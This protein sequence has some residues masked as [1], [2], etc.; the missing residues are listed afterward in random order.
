MIKFNKTVGKSILNLIQL[1]VY[2]FFFKHLYRGQVIN[3]D[4]I[5]MRFDNNDSLLLALRGPYE[6]LLTKKFKNAVKKGDTVVDIGANIGYYTLIASKLVGKTGK[7]FAFEP[8]PKNFKI[9]SE[10]VK[11]NGRNNVVLENKA[12]SNATGKNILYLYSSIGNSFYQLND[13]S[14]AKKIEVDTIK[15]DNYFSNYHRKINVVKID[16]E[17]AEFKVFR[18]MRS[19]IRK[20]PNLII[21]TEISQKI[22]KVSGENLEDYFDL[23]VKYGF[24]IYDIDD[25]KKEEKIADKEEVLKKD[26]T[27]LYCTKN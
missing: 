1:K 12:V 17:G 20:N 13:S 7:V 26:A 4:E 9:L 14:N 22:S 27:N 15:L 25:Y 16:V 8:E 2:R 19:L 21:F 6:P 24:R 3:I 18:G 10:N 5:K 11:L 23:L